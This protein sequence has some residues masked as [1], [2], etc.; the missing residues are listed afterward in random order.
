MHLLC[1]LTLKVTCPGRHEASGVKLQHLHRN[2][3][4]IYSIPIIK[5]YTV[6]SFLKTLVIDLFQGRISSYKLLQSYGNGNTCNIPGP[7]FIDFISLSLGFDID[8]LCLI[9]VDLTVWVES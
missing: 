9:T 5:R 2:S 8:L 6:Y 1:V 4:L 3:S 7:P